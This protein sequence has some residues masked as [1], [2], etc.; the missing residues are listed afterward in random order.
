M[1]PFHT[2]I[3]DY[4][5]GVITPKNALSVLHESSAGSA[6]VLGRLSPNRIPSQF[7]PREYILAPC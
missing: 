4:E 1:L 2:P 7:H 5:F 3:L 6:H